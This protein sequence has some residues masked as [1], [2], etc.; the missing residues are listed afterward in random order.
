M[1]WGAVLVENK[2]DLEIMFSAMGTEVYR[3]IINVLLLTDYAALWD[4]KVFFLQDG[5]VCYNF[6]AEKKKP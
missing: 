3:K 1:Q 4:K 2:T 5:K 6:R